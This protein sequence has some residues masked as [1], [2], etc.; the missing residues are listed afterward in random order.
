[1]TDLFYS[2]GSIYS[3]LVYRGNIKDRREIYVD[4][5]DYLSTC[6]VFKGKRSHLKTEEKIF[7]EKEKLTVLV[8]AEG[9]KL[10]ITG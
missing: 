9:K 6:I 10:V 3:K 5:Y 2:C 1:M 7:V 8:R 4:A